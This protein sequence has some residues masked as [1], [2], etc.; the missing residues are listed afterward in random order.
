MWY[1][2]TFRR[3]GISQCAGQLPSEHLIHPTGVF[4]RKESHRWGA[5]SLTDPGLLQDNMVEAAYGQRGAHS[6][7]RGSRAHDCSIHHGRARHDDQGS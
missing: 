6:E 7:A 4:S 2:T 3:G 5:P 1:V